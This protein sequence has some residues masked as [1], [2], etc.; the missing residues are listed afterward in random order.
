ME[1]KVLKRTGIFLSLISVLICGSIFRFPQI[2]SVS[3][4]WVEAMNEYELKTQAEQLNMTGLELLDYNNEQAKEQ[5]KEE[6]ITFDSQLR[7]ELPLG[8]SGDELQITQDY[9][10]QTIDIKIPYADSEYFY[11]YPM[12]GRSDNIDSLTYE[13]R[14]GYGVVE[15][16]TSQVLELETSFDKD[17]FYIDFLTPHEVYDKVVVIDAGHGGNA[18]GATKQGVNE[19]DIDLDIVL[20]LKELFDASGDD[21]SIGVYY[22]RTEDLNPSFENRVGLANKSGADL[23][24]SVHNNSTQSG[25]MSSINGTQVMYDELKGDEAL[26]SKGLAQICL[27]EVTAQTG[28]SNKGLV[29]GNSIY[30]IRSSEVP[31][32]LIEVGFMTNQTELNNLKS[33]EYQKKVAQGIYNA[34]LRA[35]AEGY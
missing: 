8:V 13:S 15:F 35:F 19:K 18:P 1:E 11:R 34:I 9:V 21:K 2:R 27:E 33:E 24:I 31:V 29:E 30:I 4:L 7:L 5:A 20:K 17:Y 14:E 26:G 12:L 28:S 16:V 3:Q 6:P 22:T 32:A 25:K 10:T 23:F